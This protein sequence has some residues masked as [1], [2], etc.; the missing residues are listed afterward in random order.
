MSNQVKFPDLDTSAIY[1]CSQKYYDKLLAEHNLG[2]TQF[3]LLRQ[4]YESEGI[5]MNE[6]AAR[7]C[8]DKGTI[9]K[10]IQKLE[11]L[12]YVKIENSDTDKRSKILICTEKTRDLM[13]VLYNLART[14]YSYLTEDVDP[15][16]MELFSEVSKKLLQKARSYNNITCDEDTFRFYGLQK[17]TLLDYPGHMAA[18]LFTGGCNF[19]CPFCHN[20]SLVF[21]NESEG[22]ISQEDIFFYLNKRKGI[23]DGVCISGGEPLLHEG[24][25]DFIREVKELGLSVKIDTNGSCFERLKY[26]VEEGLV[27]YVA[28]DIKN[29]PKRYG[30]TTGLEGQDISEIQKSVAYLLQGHV[31]YE[32]RT[33]IVKEFHEDTDFDALGEWIKGAK[34]YFLQNFL[35]QGSCIR[36]GLHALEKEELFAIRDKMKKY[37]PDTQ[38]R[39]VEE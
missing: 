11:Q 27:D 26:L 19:R 23:V 37:I 15:K 4:I 13:P 25:V 2:Y 31:D 22:E 33:T 12:N 14:W 39:G 1:R 21:L 32:F 7:G 5:G 16:E 38:V 8:F 35:D 29:E 36:E 34:R 10:S 28:M 17:L 6:L 30:E 18:T 3:I 20:R 24:I 9:T